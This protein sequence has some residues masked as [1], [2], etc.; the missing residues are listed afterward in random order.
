MI[1]IAQV[2]DED[3]VQVIR[4]ILR[5]Y[6]EWQSTIAHEEFEK[7][8]DDMR[9]IPTFSDIDEELANIPGVF[10]PEHGGALLLATN[11]SVGVGCIAMLQKDKMNCELKRM[12]V[13]PSARGQGIGRKLVSV[14]IEQARSQNYQ[15]M[16]LDSLKIMTTAHYL[17]H[18]AGFKTTPIPYEVPDFL[19]PHVVYMEMDI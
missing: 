5:E 3:Q 10:A 12:Y 6:L 2:R 13:K 19:K 17:Y 4:G 1:E 11:Q 8:V 14:L 9:E 16:F 15:L 7:Y 18:Q